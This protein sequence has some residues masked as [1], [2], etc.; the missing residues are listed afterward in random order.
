MNQHYYIKCCPTRARL[1][2]Y[3]SFQTTLSVRSTIRLQRL[4]KVQT[5]T[6]A[7]Q[8]L[9]LYFRT[10]VQPITYQVNFL[11]RNEP[12][13]FRLA[14]RVRALNPKVHMPIL[15]QFG[16]SC[17]QVGHDLIDR[18]KS[19]PEQIKIT[20][21]IYKHILCDDESAACSGIDASMQ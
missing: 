11:S 17:N 13:Y 5:I 8:L 2:R 19:S 4:K 21:S 6:D 16:S 12:N 14:S 18:V 7:F 10:I 9:N 20:A 1:A 3:K 15:L